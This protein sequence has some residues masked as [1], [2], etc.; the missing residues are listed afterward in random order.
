MHE[1]NVKS[2]KAV[3]L[4]VSMEM[5]VFVELLLGRSPIMFL[6]CF[7]QSF[8]VCQ[9]ATEV[10]SGLFQLVWKVSKSQLLLEAINLLLRHIDGEWLGGG[11]G[12]WAR[13]GGIDGLSTQ[14]L[15]GQVSSLLCDAN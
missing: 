4:E 2:A 6:P 14:D 1:M 10:P 12:G 13:A 7:G 3:N 5:W 9:R 15:K 11:H 8:D